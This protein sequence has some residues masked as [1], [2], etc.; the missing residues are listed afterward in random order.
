MSKKQITPEEWNSISK[1]EQQM[2]MNAMYIYTEKFRKKGVNFTLTDISAIAWKFQVP[3]PTG[4]DK[5]KNPLFK[6]FEF[7]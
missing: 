7:K 2:R 5:Y 4:F 1:R 3:T 6:G